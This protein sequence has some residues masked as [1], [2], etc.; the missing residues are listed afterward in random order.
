M[1]PTDPH[2]LKRLR[3]ITDDVIRGFTD[4]SLYFGIQHS[5]L[6]D[7]LKQKKVLMNPWDE[8]DEPNKGW[9][10]LFKPFSRIDLM[11]K[12]LPTEGRKKILLAARFSQLI[13]K[14][15]SG[16]RIVARFV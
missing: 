14:Q 16:Y 13:L 1:T 8:W 4:L 9:S 2:E 6:D 10:S 7:Q 15:N 11:L 5:R 3:D 12:Y